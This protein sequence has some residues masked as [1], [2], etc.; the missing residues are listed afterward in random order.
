MLHTRTGLSPVMI[1][2]ADELAALRE[3]VAQVPAAGSQSPPPIALVT[4]EAGVGKTRLLAELCATAEATVYAAQAQEGDETRPYGLLREA[5]E[6]LVSGWDR[7]PAALQAREHHVRRVLHPLLALEGAASRAAPA[8]GAE[9]EPEDG[10]AAE[11]AQRAAVAIVEHAVGEGPALVVLEDLHWADPESVELLA[12]LATTPGLPAA[13]VATFRAEQ[14]DRRHPLPTVLPALERQRNVVQI[15][16]ERLS[17]D[18]MAA[19]LEA[20]YGRSAPGR[21]VQAVHARTRGNPFFVEELIVGSGAADPAALPEAELPW[22]AAEAVLRRA[23]A[24]EDRTRAVLDA[25]AVLGPRVRFEL[26]AAVTGLAEHDLLR[27]LHA[28]QRHGFVTEHEPDVFAFRHALAREAVAGQLFERERRNLH[29]AALDAL[30]EEGSCDHVARAQHAA[31]AGRTSELAAFA[32]EGARQLLA[33]GSSVEALRLAELAL[34]T[35]ERLSLEAEAALREHA[36]QAAWRLGALEAALHH[37]QAWHEGAQGLGDRAQQARALRHLASVQWMLGDAEEHWATMLRALETAEGL[38]EHP[39][40]AWCASYR[41]QAHLL[42]GDGDEAVRWADEALALT[43]RL[44]ADE[45]APF[46]LVNKGTALLVVPGREEEGLA[47]LHRAAAE[48]DRRGQPKALLRACNNALTYLLTEPPGRLEEARELL[49]TSDEAARRY[50]HELYRRGDS[51]HAVVLASI[52]GDLAAAERALAGVASAPHHHRGRQLARADLAAERGDVDAVR[53]ALAEAEVH[54]QAEADAPDVATSPSE[55][56]PPEDPLA[57]FAPQRTQEA[58]VCASIAELL[59]QPELASRSLEVLLADGGQSSWLRWRALAALK[60]VTQLARMSTIDPALLQRV[61]TATHED[62]H[63]DKPIDQALVA[64]AQ[65]AL[66][67]RAEQPEAARDRARAALAVPDLP[68]S[69]AWYAEQQACLARAL[70]QVGERGG[71][72][73]AAGAALAHLQ[74]WPGVRRERIA[75]LARRLG[76]GSEERAGASD[77]LTR[78]ERDVLA[79]LAR[80]ASNGDIA[81]RLFISRKTA[82]VHVSN[83]LR[84]TGTASRT[85]AAAWAHAQGLVDAEDPAR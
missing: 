81:A 3:L 11:E 57:R 23:D 32:V 16:V 83:I 33:E 71:A 46:T 48:A 30:E 78:R 68:L 43:E 10:Q 67:E 41:S 38:G 55:A 39:E 47:L 21:T 73:E 61:V 26:L 8:P 13:L 5:L 15:P 65:A 50:G 58:A 31:A 66:A 64:G 56:T 22:N 28:L 4:G 9:P 27:C 29:A 14:L 35:C 18:E 37:A 25:L 79:L 45:V 2:R 51:S 80:G 7:L 42:R 1:G 76:V 72:R 52:D 85:E 19:L 70:A 36:S 24:L 17:V 62:L 44:G 59:D 20:V 60:S 84:K 63:A 75:A 69:A 34:R 49:V 40:R 82:A 12:A 77:G 74:R 53:S 54:G 6:P